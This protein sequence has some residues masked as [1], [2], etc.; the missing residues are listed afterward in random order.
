MAH[1]RDQVTEAFELFDSDG[2]GYLLVSEVASAIRALGHILTDADVKNLLSKS[3][4]DP[5]RGSRVD[6]NKFRQMHGSL[7]PQNYTRQLE[8]AF[9][10]VDKDGSGYV[11]ATELKHLLTN[12]GDKLS[13]DDFTTLLEELDIDSNGRIQFKEFVRLLTAR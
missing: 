10:T 8:E 9:K 3:G 12:M 13:N 5:S 1:N 6:I 7:P 4:I 11:M 2:D